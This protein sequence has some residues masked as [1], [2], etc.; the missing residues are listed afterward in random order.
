MVNQ[1][2]KSVNTYYMYM[3]SFY[4]FW[5]QFADYK[6]VCLFDCEDLFY[7][8]LICFIAHVRQFTT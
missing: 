4:Y 8:E 2:C 1:I 7:G 3:K 6:M 5:G